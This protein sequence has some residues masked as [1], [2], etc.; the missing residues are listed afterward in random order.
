[1]NYE[2]IFLDSLKEDSRFATLEFIFE[3][4][5]RFLRLLTSST[6][7][8]RLV[9]YSIIACSYFVFIK[10]VCPRKASSIPY[11][12][13]VFP[14]ILSFNTMRSSLAASIILF[15]LVSLKNK[16]IIISILLFISAVFIHRMSIIFLPYFCFYF[17]YTTFHI[18]DNKKRL[19]LITVLLII[20]ITLCATALRNYIVN[21]L[22]SIS[23]TDSYYITSN[24]GQS[25]FSYISY[26]LPLLLLMVFWFIVSD[27]IF[28]KQNAFL[29]SIVLYDVIISP[30][31]FIFGM[32]RTN[33]Y[34]Y[35]ARLTLW[36]VLI[37]KFR[38]EFHITSRPIINSIFVLCFMIW[39]YNR[40]NATWEDSAIMP[41]QLTWC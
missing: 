11:I 27:N 31:S 7:V 24:I 22:P 14:F 37:Y 20:A 40:I 3:Y 35:I 12:L 28:N 26:L 41:Y 32:W 36:A 6:I 16:R 17:F 4:Y 9:S 1:M 34:L 13:L 38:K 8:Y 21:F 19:L 15:G 2:S 30:A 33:E 18:Y 10:N 23:S 29:L 25:V 39:L 5:N